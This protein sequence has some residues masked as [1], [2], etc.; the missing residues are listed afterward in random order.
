MHGLSGIVTVECCDVCQ[1]GF[2]LQ[3]RVDAG[4]RERRGPCILVA[5]WDLTLLWFNFG[6]STWFNSSYFVFAYSVS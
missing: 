4:K 2:G 1:E 6:Y 3:D 5:A